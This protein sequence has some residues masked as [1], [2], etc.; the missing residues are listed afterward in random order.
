MIYNKEALTFS[1]QLQQLKDRGLI[2]DS[3]SK[4]LKYLE[5]I[6]YYRLE[7]YWWPLQDN[8]EAHTFKEGST[9]QKVIQLYNFDAEIRILIFSV[10]EKI[11]ISLR[12]KLVYH[13]SHKHGPWWFQNTTL[14]KDTPA[15]IKTLEK[16]REEV[17][18]SKE[19]YMKEHRKKYK[20]DKRF[21]PAW[22]TLELTSFGGLSKLYGNI[23]NAD[24]LKDTIAKEFG[25]VNH[26]FLPSW[27]QAIA[28]IRNICAHHGRLWNKNL[29][30]SVKLLPKPPN[31]W[32]IDVPQQ[33]EFKHLYVHLCIMKYLLDTI[34]PKNKMAKNL[35]LI[36]I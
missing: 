13:M 2:V 30:A 10:I 6:S 8:K 5:N 33:H 18:R 15:L 14:F 3:D 17:A 23:N 36:H 7:G 4:A 29:P 27:L 28:Q 20:D 26:T 11:E 25:A 24:K 34:H 9:F 21:P 32:I 35:S 1:Q 22:K 19:V 12:T 31:A 16:L